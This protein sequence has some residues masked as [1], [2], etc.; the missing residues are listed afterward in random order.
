MGNYSSIKKLATKIISI[1]K[2]K[3]FSL[4]I[5]ILFSS[6]AD[7]VSIGAIVPFLG[8]LTNPE[9]ITS[10]PIVINLFGSSGLLEDKKLFLLYISAIFIF[11]VLLAGVVRLVML[12]KITYFSYSVGADISSEFYTK[13]IY[14]SYEEQIKTNS[15]DAIAGITAKIN[16]TIS[17]INSLVM[18][19]GN[20][21]VFIFISSLVFYI[22]YQAAL[23]TVFILSLCYVGVAKYTRRR[24]VNNSVIISEKTN[25]LVSILQESLGGIRDVIL[26]KLQPFFIEGYKPIDKELRLA[27]GDNIFRGGAPRYIMETIAILIIVAISVYLVFS[28][29]NIS[30][31][32]PILGAIA[33]AGQRLLPIMQQIFQAWANIMGHKSELDYVMTILERPHEVIKS[34]SDI[35]FQNKFEL[36]NLSYSYIDDKDDK[37]EVLKDVNLTINKGDIIGIVGE[38]GS[39]KSTVV[40]IIMGL[41]VNI[42]GGIYVDGIKINYKN[43][44]DWRKKISHVPQDVFLKDDSI[45]SNIAFGSYDEQKDDYRINQVIEMSQLKDFIDSLEDGI[46]HRVG[47]RGINLSG[48]QKQRIGIARAIYKNSDL[49]VL[50]EA[51]SALDTKTESKIMDTVNM[52]HKTS[53][54]IIIAHR[55][56]TLKNCN[57]IFQVSNSNLKELDVKDF[58]RN[59]EQV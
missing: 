57:R 43:I 25:D 16:S 21:I 38:T 39:G 55:I 23:S 7:I 27:M 20:M 32:I 2:K 34:T 46:K 41:L 5:L 26:D 12:K 59:Q 9:S 47:E 36:R 54:I 15:A 52:L 56:T 35:N 4:I 10:L 30:F 29:D 17:I 28:L 13:I 33:L 48:G 22:N 14:S 6:I 11:L 42:D 31:V 50:D 19:L 51:T 18:L 53:T 45:A 24:L 44:P 37:K 58:F 3:I 49:I 1:N 40:D 8:L